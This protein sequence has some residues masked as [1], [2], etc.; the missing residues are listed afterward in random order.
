MEESTRV[1][2]NELKQDVGRIDSN[3]DTSK[4]FFSEQLAT[5]QSQAQQALERTTGLSN[6]VGQLSQQSTDMHNTLSAM[7][8]HSSELTRCLGKMMEKFE[9]LNFDLPSIMDHW[10]T[11]RQGEG[12]L[13]AAQL[14]QGGWQSG[15]PTVPKLLPMLP[16]PIAS[17]SSVTRT[18]AAGQPSTAMPP[19]TGVEE[20][21]TKLFDQF[22]ISQG[23][24]SAR[25]EGLFSPVER[26]SVDAG[27]GMAGS[28]GRA[29]DLVVGD[30]SEVEMDSEMETGSEE[31]GEVK[32]E[33]EVV[34][35]VEELDKDGEVEMDVQAASEGETEIGDTD[36]EG[37]DADEEEKV[38]KSVSPITTADLS[39]L[40][41]YSYPTT[42]ATSQSRI[43]A[44]QSRPRVSPNIIQAQVMSPP[45]GLLVAQP[46]VGDTT[47]SRPS[48]R[49]SVS[50]ST[51]SSRG[52]GGKSR[53]ASRK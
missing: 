2:F 23:S 18:Q 42:P 12:T 16:I 44:T 41:P 11:Q 45:E 46:T 50:V 29:D 51:T 48:T 34:V 31:D 26:K 25:Q 49:S 9:K 43:A 47:R 32:E 21:P 24:T 1:Q 52:K 7:H 37:E 8:T 53:K 5:V 15:L 38:W 36:A 30:D 10:A 40:T 6:Q 20:S 22:I 14:Q 39:S 4:R 3:A 13:N 28:S 27:V 33:D 35:K 19:Q 17:Q